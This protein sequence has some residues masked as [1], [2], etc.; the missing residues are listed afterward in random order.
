MQEA[1][2]QKENFDAVV[3]AIKP[4][5]DCVDLE[6]AAQTDG[7]RQRSDTIIQRCKAA[8]EN[9]KSFN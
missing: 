8:W 5:L 9:F 3:V 1:K 6:L 2:I 7:R 4:M